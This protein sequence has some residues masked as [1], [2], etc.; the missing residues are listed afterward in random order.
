VVVGDVKVDEVIRAVAT[1][2]AA[3]PARPAPQAQAQDA[4]AIRFPATGAAPVDL[5]HKGRADQAIAY[6]AWRSNGLF[7]D[8][9][10]A[11]TINVAAQ[12]LENRLVDRVRIAE[13]STYSPSVTSSPSDVFPTFG[14]VAASVETPPAKIDSFYKAVSEITADLRAKGPTVDE[15]DRA[16]RPRIETLTKAQQTNEY[17]LTWIAGADRDPRRLEIVRT[18]LPG[19]H[20]VTAADV[21]AAAAQYLTDAK[22]WKLEVTPKGGAKISAQ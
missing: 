17:W 4:L 11:R 3:L 1:T 10:Q 2:F 15:L 12:V 18:T 9:Q 16:V 22:A 7:A 14:V 21:Q 6:E 8:P 5:T 13:G 19:Y 20:R